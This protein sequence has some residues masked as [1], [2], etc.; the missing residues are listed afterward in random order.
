MRVGLRIALGLSTAGG[1]A[2]AGSIRIVSIAGLLAALALALTSCTHTVELFP[3]DANGTG[4]QGGTSSGTGG[5]GGTSSNG[6]GFTGEGGCPPGEL[7]E[8][9]GTCLPAGIPPEMCAQ[10]FEP[11]GNQGCRPILPADDCADGMMAIPGE[12]ACREV[13]PCGSGTWGDIPVEGNT[14]HVDQSYG[15]GGS[16]GS[17]AA[18][19]TTIAQGISAAQSGAI[20]AIAAG[21]YVENL[22]VTKRVRLWGRCPSMVEVVVADTQYPT[23]LFRE[24]SSTSEVRDVALRAGPVPL[25]VSGATDVLADRVRVHEATVHGIE[26]STVLGPASLT[27]TRSLVDANEGA[28]M[29]IAGS[30]T[31]VEET[32]IRNNLPRPS[33]QTGGR[34]IVV[35]HDPDTLDRSELGLRRSLLE[36]NHFEG[37]TVLG[38]N[39]TVE[40][41]VI[42]RTLP[43]QS[44]QLVGLGINAVDDF[45]S[46]TGL[47]SVLVVRTSVIDS[48]R[49]GGIAV[50]GALATVE[51][52]VVRDTTAN[53]AD[54]SFGGRGLIAQADYITGE[55]AELTLR[56]SV[57][58]GNQEAGLFVGGAT[59]VVLATIVRDT[60]PTS[61]HAGRALQV[62]D[63]QGGL[64]SLV[65][66]GSLV[67]RSSEV[68]MMLGGEVFAEVETLLVDETAAT[69]AGNFGDG[70]VVAADGSNAPTLDISWS[71]VEDS[72]RVGI[73][74]FGGIVRLTGNELRCNAIDLNAESALGFQPFFDDRGGNSCGCGGDVA[75]CGPQSAGLEPP[76]PGNDYPLP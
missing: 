10:G 62:Q 45:E 65:L 42:R 53:A 14:E 1:L 64:T 66:R 76:V 63:Y 26:V 70:A 6:G 57:V 51:H 36:D 21:S 73:A 33:D 54:E 43:R 18:P 44:D 9:D 37:I 55:P 61:I 69:E 68:A 75:G 3:A 16:N 4:G 15:G 29:V 74:A 50:S 27:L 67:E 12:T 11:D 38:S 22:E 31:T 35:Q 58:A 48:N 46:L 2:A 71:R 56:S 40:S 34:G 41:S 13:A 32:V 23:I 24:G 30:A 20:V 25:G 60:L 28:G 19:W 5:T 17:A 39:A 8:S 59:V 47:R 7:Y 52:T 49:Q 72:A